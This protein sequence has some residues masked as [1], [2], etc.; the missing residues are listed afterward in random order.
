[1][2][3]CPIKDAL[4]VA[5]YVLRVEVGP[6]LAAPLDPLQNVSWGLRRLRASGSWLDVHVRSRP[7]N[8]HG[9]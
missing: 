3:V 4:K 2:L 8:P 7:L 1:M 5:A 6:G 9:T